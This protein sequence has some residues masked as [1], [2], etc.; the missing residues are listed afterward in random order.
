MLK[1][2]NKGLNI[3]INPSASSLYL[4]ASVDFELQGTKPVTV[5]RERPYLSSRLCCDT[6]QIAAT[7]P[8]PFP[9]PFH[10]A[11]LVPPNPC[12]PKAVAA[13]LP[14]ANS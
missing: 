1:E 2:G 9:H 14:I 11:S 5:T 4:F 3:D 12:P 13:G 10:L 8:L 7:N 6:G